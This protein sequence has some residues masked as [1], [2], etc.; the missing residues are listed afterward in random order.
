M[1]SSRLFKTIITAWLI[2][3]LL[4]S[5]TEV[6]FQR[7]DAD[8]IRHQYTGGWEHFVGGGISS[9]DCDGDAFP[10]LYLA[11]GSASATLLR[12]RS[13][14]ANGR[15]HFEAQTPDSLSI[16]QVTGSYPVDID[17]D[18][19]LDLVVLR[20]GKNLLLRGQGGC[21]FSPFPVSLGFNSEERWTT[22]FSASW[23]NNQSLPT[24]AFGN[25]V[26][27]DQPQGPF[28]ACD[29]N[30][31]YRPLRN[32]YGA[33]LKLTPG[34]CALSMLF[35]DWGRN[36][37]MDLRISNDRHY[38]VR[39]GS[40]QLWAMESI[41]RLYSAKDGWID[42][43]LW[44][45]GIASRDLTGDG[46]PEIFLTSMGDQKLQ[47]LDRSSN[48]PRYLNA[49][50]DR[51]I[52]A[53]RP[54]TGDDG[55]PSTGWHAEFADIN[56]DGRDDI[57]IAKG[58]VEQMMSSA[59]RD[60]NNLLMQNAAGVFE[61]KAVSAGIVSF[62]KGRGAT[63]TD[64]N[65]DG[66][67]DLAVLNRNAA[68]EIYQNRSVPNGHWL[69]LRLQQAGINPD[70]IGAWIEVHAQNSSWFREITIG[71]GHA[72]GAC[73]YQHFGLGEAASVSLRVTWPDGVV[74][75]WVNLATNR[76]YQLTRNGAGAVV[77]VN[78]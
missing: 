28:E 50:F 29:D 4:A 70:A 34:F 12:N 1:A 7:V 5:A 18:G 30:R 19:L 58:N 46:Y 47:S 16:T 2:W 42:Y 54:F 15:L 52:T 56:D 76:R 23:E 59:V 25:Y 49:S 39:G 55:R 38:Y 26:D 74:S 69:L 36:G 63:L 6:S 41:P 10:E 62:A 14:A 66:L 44:G 67:P 60:P 33:A 27:R 21:Q 57:F 78:E 72:G 37:R 35:S 11:G 61:E 51:G 77:A 43:S 3:P 65:L 64:L 8:S 53:H 31:L 13:A 17:S 45:M 73:G 71:G 40:E 20:V 75:D 48:H 24:L 32:Q 68:V 9:F 22:A